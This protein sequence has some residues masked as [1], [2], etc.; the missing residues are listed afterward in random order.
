MYMSISSYASISALSL[1]FRI[2]LMS[3][4]ESPVFLVLVVFVLL[5][6]DDPNI[7]IRIIMNMIHPI[8][9]PPLPIFPSLPA[10]HLRYIYSLPQLKSNKNATIKKPLGTSHFMLCK[11]IIAL[12]V[13]LTMSLRRCFPPPLP[14]PWKKHPGRLP[15][16]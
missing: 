12:P 2:R 15:I 11:L 9:V 16:G 1:S 8:V 10:T 6:S 4:F 3:F 7:Q 14:R 13:S 5:V